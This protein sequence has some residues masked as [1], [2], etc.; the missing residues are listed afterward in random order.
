MMRVIHSGQRN[1][2][3]EISHAWDVVDKLN[4]ELETLR[5]D[6]MMVPMQM[7]FTDPRYEPERARLR[8]DISTA[9]D[10]LAAETERLAAIERDRDAAC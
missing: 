10:R 5:W 1:F 8:G 6:Y 4:A 9:T 2:E 3:Q 7:A